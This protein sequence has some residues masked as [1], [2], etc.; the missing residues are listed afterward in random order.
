MPSTSDAA[1]GATS[2]AVSDAAKPKVVRPYDMTAGKVQ[3]FPDLYN[4]YVEQH[5]ES[6][7]YVAKYRPRLCDNR[8]IANFTLTHKDAIHPIVCDRAEGAH[9][10]D[11]DGNRIVDMGGGFGPVLFGHNPPF[12]R[13]A[14]TQMM[15]QG[16]WGLGFEHEV[17]GQCSEKVRRCC[18][19]RAR[20]VP[21]DTQRMPI[22][23]P[24]RQPRSSAWS[25][26]RG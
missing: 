19:R 16:S 10:W 1:S 13:D 23:P 24:S 14:I 22:P 17:V 18:R 20:A 25:G 2:G 12:V 26:A 6:K 11:R 8:N 5:R 9:V 3:L 4:E 7:A 21:A 15:T